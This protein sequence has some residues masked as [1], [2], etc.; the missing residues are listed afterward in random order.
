MYAGYT[1]A[2]SVFLEGKPL[3]ITGW[4][5]GLTAILILHWRSK[6]IGL[7]GAYRVVERVV[8][9]NHA[10]RRHQKRAW[11][12]RNSISRLGPA[13]SI[14]PP[15]KQGHG[16]QDHHELV[17]LRRGARRT[18]PNFRAKPALD[19]MQL[20][21]SISTPKQ[22]AAEDGTTRRREGGRRPPI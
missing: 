12:R 1:A 14:S 19:L 6:V 3:N 4:Y 17:A 11:Q 5:I 15:T 20:V 2:T 8:L 18:V 16:Y 13:C 10:R 22:L 7:R 21:G 9:R